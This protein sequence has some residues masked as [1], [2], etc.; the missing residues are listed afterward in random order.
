[1]KYLI[2]L[3]MIFSISGFA[4]GGKDGGNGGVGVVCRDPQTKIII[5][6]QLLDL[7]E[8]VVL[9]NQS[10]DESLNKAHSYKRAL[11]RLGPYFK[12]QVWDQLQIVQNDFHYIPEGNQLVLTDDAIPAIKPIGCD[13][14][15][16]AHYTTDGILLVSRE[17][18]SALPIIHQIALLFH[19]SIYTLARQAGAENSQSTRRAVAYLLA[20]KSDSYQLSR[21]MER[22]SRFLNGRYVNPN[23]QIVTFKKD[24]IMLAKVEKIIDDNQTCPVGLSSLEAIKGEVSVF[25]SGVEP[26]YYIRMVGDIDLQMAFTLESLKIGPTID[27]R[28]N[29]VDGAQ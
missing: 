11:D 13:F 26:S 6:A 5:K 28:R 27:F 18:Y 21:A 15:Q 3:S 17:I 24:S 16:I 4:G 29:D 8:G 14:E 20:D 9:F 23:C 2:F 1:M 22:L 10:Y 7:Y 12:K 19:E 25:K